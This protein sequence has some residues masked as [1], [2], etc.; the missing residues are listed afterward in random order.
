MG[1]PGGRYTGAAG[2]GGHRH[3]AAAGVLLSRG[4]GHDRR[5][6][7]RDADREDVPPGPGTGVPGPGSLACPVACARLPAACGLRPFCPGRCACPLPNSSASFLPSSP[8][9]LSLCGAVEVDSSSVVV[10]SC[11]ALSSRHRP[12]NRG[13]GS[14]ALRRLYLSP[15]GGVGRREGQLGAED[16]QHQPGLEPHV[17]LLAC[18]DPGGPLGAGQR[19]PAGRAA[20]GR[21]ARHYRLARR[22]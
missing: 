3:D 21:L 10:A 18:V 9:G 19:A 15:A 17:G 2:T 6:R 14:P 4:G 11:G 7:D 13:S 12:A 22:M 8:H 5:G 20:R 16:L 1:W